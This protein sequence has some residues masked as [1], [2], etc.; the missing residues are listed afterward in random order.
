MLLDVFRCCLLAFS[1]RVTQV[2]A[3]LSWLSELPVPHSILRHFASPVSRLFLGACSE[4]RVW[5]V[6]PL[7][8]SMS[9]SVDIGLWSR[10]QH[11][12]N[13]CLVFPTVDQVIFSVVCWELVFQMSSLDSP[14]LR[15]EAQCGR[16]FFQQSSVYFQSWS[17]IWHH[18]W[19]GRKKRIGARVQY[20]PNQ[21]IIRE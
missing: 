11:A 7:S 14:I 10:L 2:T 3:Y 9:C 19:N 13:A 8:M 6:G 17:S 16:L 5:P 20:L 21:V 18:C 15:R 12:S 4:N 1:V